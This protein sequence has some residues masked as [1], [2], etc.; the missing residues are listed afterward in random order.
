MPTEEEIEK[1][2]DE[3]AQ[4]IVD[5]VET[6]V[7]QFSEQYGEKGGEVLDV[8]VR[9]QVFVKAISAA[10]NMLDAPVESKSEIAAFISAETNFL[11]TKYVQETKI[12]LE[13]IKK[14]G[15]HSTN[16]VEIIGAMNVGSKNTAH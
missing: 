9:T 10:I 15:E 1:M 13:L 12:P 11:I 14:A 3:H 7:K 4:S 2:M 16:L 6:G 8:F 5:V